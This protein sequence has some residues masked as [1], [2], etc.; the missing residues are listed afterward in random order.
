[1]HGVCC[2]APTHLNSLCV[3]SLLFLGVRGSIHRHLIW[4]ELWWTLKGSSDVLAVCNDCRNTHWPQNRKRSERSNEDK[5][6]FFGGKEGNTIW[7]LLQVSWGF[8]LSQHTEGR[9]DGGYLQS[10]FLESLDKI[11]CWSNLGCG[12]HLSGAVLNWG[13]VPFCVFIA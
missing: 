10:D 9:Q 2:A 6:M 7:Y 4:E 3:M 13:S 12:F 5:A 1:M 11:L 8:Q